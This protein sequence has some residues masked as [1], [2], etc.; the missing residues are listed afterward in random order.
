MFHGQL[1]L[2]FP[3]WN[4]YMYKKGLTISSMF[5]F[6]S[7]FLTGYLL[8]DN[9]NLTDPYFSRNLKNNLSKDEY[10]K[11]IKDK[12]EKNIKIERDVSGAVYYQDDFDGA[13]DTSSLKKQRL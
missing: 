9:L 1:I 11:K 12:S 4:K 5:L 6:I 13:N 7:L 3:I 2:K 8:T 10:L